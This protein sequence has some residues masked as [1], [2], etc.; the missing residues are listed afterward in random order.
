MRSLR[1]V[2]LLTLLSSPAA[3]SDGPPRVVVELFTSQGCSS[4][5]PADELLRR[6][7]N[8]RGVKD[9]LIPLSFHVDYWNHIGWKDPYSQ[10]AWSKR[11]RRYAAK[12]PSGVY[13]PQVVIDGRAH[14]VGSRGREVTDGITA[15]RKRAHTP[16]E[17][18]VRRS[19]SK[20]HATARASYPAG[21][22]PKDLQLVFALFESS[23][24]TK[25][26]SGEN[27]G[28]TL[29]HDFVV[30][31]LKQRVASGKDK[32]TASVSF[33]IEDGWSASDLGVASF[34]QETRSLHI[35]GGAKATLT[36]AR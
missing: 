5:P 14:V 30:R 24:V 23:I 35:H 12:L 4:C 22:N 21:V 17:V 19:G 3:A 28:E 34:W 6:L 33:T 31:A 7:G 11:Q 27:S 25:V 8:A 2:A 29:A 18:A 1:A 20:V 26:A 15:A 32:A 13:T 10:R 9:G 16:F 36:P